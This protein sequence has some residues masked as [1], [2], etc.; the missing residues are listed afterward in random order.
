LFRDKTVF[1]IGAGASAEADFPIGINADNIV[2]MGFSFQEQNIELLKPPHETG[3][4]KVFATAFDS[5]DSLQGIYRN[6]ILRLFNGTRKGASMTSGTI[7][8]E[9]ASRKCSEFLW[10]YS[11]EIS[12][13]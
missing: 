12:N 6:R 3:P 7:S 9:M 13:Y 10:A 5:S 2:F 11:R 8:I 1:V 4:K